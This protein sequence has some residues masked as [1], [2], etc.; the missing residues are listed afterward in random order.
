VNNVLSEIV[1]T[2]RTIL[3]TGEE[4]QAN[5]YIDESCGLL[6]QAAIKAERPKIW[7]GG[8]SGFWDFDSLHS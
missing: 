5:S 8:W 1:R 3:S 6:L 4:I 2:G 7:R